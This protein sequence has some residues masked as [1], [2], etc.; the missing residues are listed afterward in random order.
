MIPHQ[1][2]IE[3][4]RQA[5][6]KPDRSSFLALSSPILRIHCCQLRDQEVSLLCVP[7][8]TAKLYR[9]DF[10]TSAPGNPNK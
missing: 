6:P 2:L 8:L 4:D 10:N 3:S 1:Y 7:P 9:K 5:I